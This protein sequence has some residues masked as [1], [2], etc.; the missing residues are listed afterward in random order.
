[1]VAACLKAIFKS[2]CTGRELEHGKH[3]LEHLVC[4]QDKFYSRIIGNVVDFNDSKE[5]F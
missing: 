1:V 2:L 3:H 5:M 4:L